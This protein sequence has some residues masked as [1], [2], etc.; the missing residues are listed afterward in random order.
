MRNIIGL[1]HRKDVSLGFHC[2]YTQSTE[3][4]RCYQ[5]KQIFHHLEQ[6]LHVLFRSSSQV[7]VQHLDA[8]VSKGSQIPSWTPRDHHVLESEVVS[9]LFLPHLALPNQNILHLTLMDL[10]QYYWYLQ[11][12]KS[13]AYLLVSAPKISPVLDVL[14][15]QNF[16][17]EDALRTCW[18]SW[19]VCVILF[20]GAIPI[21]ILMKNQNF[22]V[23]MCSSPTKVLIMT[24]IRCLVWEIS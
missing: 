12:N 8:W 20:C 6:Q 4:Y 15:S 23:I 5:P 17:P 21:A 18:Q 1:S 14:S 19:R 11:Y 10:L 13:K 7:V 9:Q 2:A 24:Y 22:E 16:N 3:L